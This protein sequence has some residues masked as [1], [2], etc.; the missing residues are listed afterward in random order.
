MYFK[1]KV[2]NELLEWKRLIQIN[3]LFCLKVPDGLENRRSRKILPKMNINHIFNR[4]FKNS[5]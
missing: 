3:T 1:R 5:E 2:Y 4:F